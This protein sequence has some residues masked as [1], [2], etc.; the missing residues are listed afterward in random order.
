MHRFVWFTLMGFLLLPVCGLAAQNR[1][2]PQPQ[3]IT[4]GPGHLAVRGLEI[5]FASP[6]SPEDRFAADQLSKWLGSRAGSEIPTWETKGS[7]PAIVL[8]RTG[9]VDALPMPGEKPGPDSRESYELRVTPDGVTIRARSSAGIFYGAETLRQLVEGEG[10]QASLPEVS[11]HDW[12]GMVYRGTMVDMSHGPLPTVQ[13]VERQLDFMAR[14][15]MNQYYFYSEDSIELK[16]FPL[17]NPTGRFTQQDVRA[18]IAYARQRHI[19]VIP[20]LELYGHQHD[21]FRVERYS[22]LSDL[23]H[24]TEFDPRNPKVM[25]LLANWIDQFAQMFSSPFV[26]IGF[27]ET[28]QIQM[29]VKEGGTGSTPTRLFVDQL[30]SVARLF[31]A[32]GKHV[33]AWADIMV[34]YPGIVSQLP[35]GIIAV[36]WQ[37]DWQPK[38]PEYQHY[39]KPLTAEKTPHIIATGVT[40]W[41]QIAPDFD[42]TFKNIDTFL[43]AGRKSHAI[44]LMNTIWTDDG[45]M[46]MQM[47][48]P[49]IAYGAG[50]AWQSAPMDK[51]TFFS[52]YARLMYPPEAAP[53]VATA[54]DD[55][56]QSESVLQKVLGGETMIAM[57]RDPFN[58]Q[59]LKKCTAGQGDV[60]QARL[61]AEDAESLL[62]RAISLGGDRTTL[63][64]L[65]FGSRLLDYAGQ[66]F[67]TP[68]ELED[69]WHRLGPTRPPDEA[70]WN[71]WES[72]TTYQDHSRLVDL[73]DAITELRAEYRADWLAE[74]TPYRLASAIG[75][76]NAEYE[77]WRQLQSRLMTFSE[78]SHEGQKLPPL[79]SFAESR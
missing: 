52:D 5:E 3:Q 62:D 30:N 1:L 38:D 61:L 29:A 63:E 74:Y 49:G 56:R 24:G 14:W 10:E 11:I 13:E 42:T 7:G 58:P 35:A 19:D 73:M 2:L 64:S 31:E 20:C 37:Y 18:I 46:L 23:P 51:A 77:Y 39:L 53:E 44:G 28:F 54:L 25:K 48:Y 75:R 40:S 27:D 6:P 66:K 59:I 8:D 67:Q 76:W 16:G 33:M 43:D 65:L 78:S 22:D 68:P 26:H 79:S 60:R 36:P 72:M 9:A 69:L 71:E 50:A 57:W 4:F 70:W 45:Q 32:H 47:T 41:N 17:L 34:K 21:L 15:K 12:P 55:L